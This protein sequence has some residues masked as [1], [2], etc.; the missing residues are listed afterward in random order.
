M[1]LLSNLKLGVKI[2]FSFLIVGMLTGVIGYLGV[3]NLRKAEDLT[4]SLYENNTKLLGD[5]SA[6]TVAFQKSRVHLRDILIGKYISNEETDK[7]LNA[8]TKSDNIFHDELKRFEESVSDEGVIKSL[9]SLQNEIILY[10]PARSKVLKLAK[11]GRKEEA[12]NL[13]NGELVAYT[14]AVDDSLNKLIDLVMSQAKKKFGDGLA[15]ADSSIRSMMLLTGIG[16]ILAILFGVL[17]SK[18]ITSPIEAFRRVVDKI[19]QGDTNVILEAERK[20]EVGILFNSFRNLIEII[21]TLVADTDNLTQ[22]VVDGRLAVRAD[23]G[24]HAGSYRKI[25]ESVNKALDAVSGPLNLAGDYIVKIGQG[26][27]PPRITDSYSGDFN[28]LKNNLNACLDGLNGL[29]EASVVMQRLVVNDHTKKVEG[30]YL[31]CFSTLAQATN[32][33]RERLISMTNVYTLISIGDTSYL[34]DF[35]KIGKRS[36]EDDSLPA[37]IK[38]LENIR[39]LIEDT[40]TLSQAAVEGKLTTRADSSQ[41]VGDYRKIIEGVNN[42]LDAVVG[43]LNMAADYIDRIGKGDIPPKIL[44]IYKGDFNI[45]KN[46]LNACI[47]GLGGLTEA[48][49]VMQRMALNDHTKKVEGNYVGIFAALAEATNQ[50]RDRLLGIT[51]VFKLLATGDTSR[52]EEFKKIGRRS[53]QDISLPSMIKCMDSIHLV[54]ED[55]TMLAQAALE[56][57]LTV[58][59]DAARHEGDYRKIIEGVNNTLDALIS[60]LRMAADYVDRI[61]KGVVPPKISESYNGDFNT[62]KNNL[63]A[64]IDGLG[65]LTEANFIMQRL[66][67]NDHTKKVEGNYVGVFAT[68]AEATNLIRDRLIGITAVFKLLATGDTSR[69]EEFK[70]IGRRS[71]QDISL[72]AMIKCMDNIH[73]LIEDTTMLSQVVVEGKLTIRADTAK[74]DGDFRKIVEGV[75]QTL[76]SVIGPLNMAANCVDRI[77]KGDIP[78]QITDSYNGDFN[79]IKNNLNI[80]IEA[81]NEVTM[82]AAEIAAGNL[83]I[84]IKERSREDKLMQAMASMIHGLTDVAQNIIHA[85]SQVTAGSQELSTAADN[86]SQGATVQAGSVEEVS[87]SMEEMAASIG[88]NSENAQQTEKIALKAAEDGKESGKAVA[89]TVIAMKEIAGKI[90]IIEEIA[91]QTNL[92]ALNAAIEA[93][94]AGEHGKGFAV[95]ASE[96]RKL[97]ERSQM[98]ASEINKLSASSVQVA[99]RAGEMLGRIVP[100]IQ[101][102]ADLVQEITAASGEQTTGA[103]QINQAIQQLDRV[104]QQNAASSEQMAATSTE[105]MGQAEQLQNT[106]G[107]FKID[108]SETFTKS[109]LIMNRGQVKTGSRPQTTSLAHDVAR[110]SEGSKSSHPAARA[111]PGQEAKKPTKGVTLTLGG[112][113]KHDSIDEDF[114]RY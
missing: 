29:T 49:A 23:T 78:P 63:N 60:P 22:A 15:E 84:R 95:V 1:N 100:D 89:A 67:V 53:E 30:N 25:L 76:D 79:T 83:T 55:T 113:G 98:A 91:R 46:N 33:V 87:A 69:R 3:G 12:L 57:N 112:E 104:I 52:R 86:L 8:I 38:C 10:D 51:T 96:V 88:Q 62:I 109:H 99:E 59:A 110:G 54:I 65:G 73:Q 102:T 40:T 11:D 32:Q 31:G 39:R 97:A 18:I 61:G 5:I 114:E 66:A 24:R 37:M 111:L 34:E 92:L 42:T 9:Q 50:V 71:E 13:M 93:A 44:E 26:Q 64:C 2:F 70:K 105:L 45:I 48:N 6:A 80:L 103:G 58:R 101:K 36:E 82:A 107:F 17:I 106:V 77:S 16:V 108:N 28:T 35:K 41:H 74:H 47:E 75:N 14:Q 7:Y 85:A 43:P 72:P 20:D 90:S 4:R 27:I 94:R 56:G 19:A 68:L 21:K 81:M